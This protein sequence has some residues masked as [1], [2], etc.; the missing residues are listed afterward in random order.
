[1][2]KN[3]DLTDLVLLGVVKGVRG[4][5]GDLRI[6][7]FTAAKKDLSAYGC[8]W[9]ELGRKSYRVTVTG[10]A[11]GDLIARIDGVDDRIKAEGLKGLE[12]FIPR[13]ALP[14]LEA[15][16]FYYSDLIGL[17]AVTVDGEYL[18]AVSAVDNFGAGDV[19]EISGG[20][21]KDLMVSFELEVVTNI[22]FESG[23]LSVDPPDGLLERS[24]C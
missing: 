19:L 10:E 8:L 23:V 22:D 14:E 13:A 4:L 7:S 21:Y 15:N 2:N 3:P 9:D 12:L 6:K 11:Q 1:M 5:N 20:P 24:G 18:G 17:R 16:E